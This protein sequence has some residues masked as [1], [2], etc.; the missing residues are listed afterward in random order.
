MFSSLKTWILLAKQQ[1]L[2]TGNMNY[3]DYSN[4]MISSQFLLV[5][6]AI[7]SP[8]IKWR[9]HGSQ[10]F[11]YSPK[12]QSKKVVKPELKSMA[13]SR[14]V[15]HEYTTET[16]G[17]HTFCNLP[18]YNSFR[19]YNTTFSPHQFYQFLQPFLSLNFSKKSKMQKTLQD[20]V[21]G[22]GITEHFKMWHRK[23]FRRKE[24]HHPRPGM[25]LLG[26]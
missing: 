5:R 3:K 25:H 16:H 24:S 23:V 9:N 15:E 14:K 6:K 18:F 7:L 13:G 20:Q 19:K 26:E 21:R 2:L 10:K 12:S 11:S 1:L 8:P 22:A 17:S 4:Y